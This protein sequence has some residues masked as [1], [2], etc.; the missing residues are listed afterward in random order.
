[1]WWLDRL[2]L[3]DTRIEDVPDPEA[4][5]RQPSLQLVA[6]RSLDLP[7]LQAIGV[8]LAG[9][10]LNIEGTTLRFAGDLALTTTA[11][12]AK[13]RRVLTQCEDRVDE[14]GLGGWL[15]EPRPPVPL[16]FDR[17]LETIDTVR[18]G[19]STVVWATGFRRE[20]PWLHVDVLDA[21]GELIH[22]GGVTSAPGLYAMGLRFMRRR[23][24]TFIDGAGPDAEELAAHIAA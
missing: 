21:A 7:V 5:R 22:Q 23:K 2:G 18:S 10:L 11:A 19:I 15:D 3:L 24:S 20:Y 4:A 12:E 14:L 6:G 17:G 8:R 1:M 13:L 16:A 9:R